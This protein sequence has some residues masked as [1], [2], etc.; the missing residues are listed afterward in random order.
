MSPLLSSQKAMVFGT[1]QAGT[2]RPVVALALAETTPGRHTQNTPVSTT[3]RRSTAQSLRRRPPFRED[4]PVSRT[5]LLD[6]RWEFPILGATT[7]L[8][9]HSLAAMPRQAEERLAEYARMWKERGI[10]SWAEGWWDMPI[11]VG[12]QV[13]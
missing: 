10:R 4:G 6:Y 11:T 9:N 13:G 12:D 1:S 5:E 2:L 8:I 3:A 7:Y